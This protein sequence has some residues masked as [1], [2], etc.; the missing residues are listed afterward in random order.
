MNAATAVFKRELKGY[1]GTPLAYVFLD[2]FLVAT[3]FWTFAGGLGE[4]PFF[5]ARSK[6]PVVTPRVLTKPERDALRPTA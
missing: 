1:F 4:A 5:D 2:I 6:Q 3:L